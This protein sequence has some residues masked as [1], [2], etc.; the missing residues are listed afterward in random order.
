MHE[1]ILQ[2][3]LSVLSKNQ[4]LKVIALFTTINKGEFKNG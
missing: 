1:L 4:H 3:S 2:G